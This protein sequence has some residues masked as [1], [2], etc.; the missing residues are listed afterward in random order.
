MDSVNFYKFA[1]A[2]MQLLE[3]E[4]Y[5]FNVSEDVSKTAVLAATGNDVNVTPEEET[6]T[7]AA[8]AEHLTAV[9][10]QASSEEILAVAK[11]LENSNLI[12]TDVTS[13]L[14]VAGETATA[15]AIIKEAVAEA[16]SEKIQ[17]IVEQQAAPNISEDASLSAVPVTKN[18]WD[19]YPE[20]DYSQIQYAESVEYLYGYASRNSLFDYLNPEINLSERQS[21]WAMFTK[22][23]GSEQSAEA[24]NFYNVQRDSAR[25]SIQTNQTAGDQKVED[26][27]KQA[28]ARLRMIAEQRRLDEQMAESRKQ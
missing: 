23:A 15:A 24:N 13:T 27:R 19:Y 20:I 5:S 11:T 12:E 22:N 16:A 10:Q 3:P 8:V 28:D 14:A 4:K 1:A 26:G 17:E 7:V 21:T 9:I 2:I 18:F 6:Q 25:T